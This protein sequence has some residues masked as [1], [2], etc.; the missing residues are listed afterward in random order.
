MVIR[1]VEQD[2]LRAMAQFMAEMNA[3]PEQHS[4]H[5]DR[6]VE[7]L[8]NNLLALSRPE[9]SFV[10]AVESGRISGALGG[11]YNDDKSRMWLWGPFVAGDNWEEVALALLNGL[12]AIWPAD[13]EN[14]YTFFNQTNQRGYNFFLAQGFQHHGIYHAY[15]A[16]RPETFPEIPA[17]PELHPGQLDSYAALHNLA[18]PNTFHTG[19]DI[20][21]PLS[22]NRK[23]FV[24]AEGDEVQGYVEVSVNQ[25]PPEGYIEFL[26]VRPGQRGRG[27]GRTLLTYALHW[28]FNQ[29]QLPEVN[30]TV[31]D[32]NDNARALYE[33]VGFHLEYTGLSAKGK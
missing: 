26:A 4:L 2:E 29:R 10:V 18:F 23:L 28:C 11:D 1:K 9:D 31:R 5:C 32:D 22:E 12:R 25:F 19:R 30:L 7:D 20:L 14:S 8:T 13:L 33:S 6:T 27:L 24:L 15:K 3:R 21:E 17:I 16:L